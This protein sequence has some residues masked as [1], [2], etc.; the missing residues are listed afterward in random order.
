E[1]A[2]FGKFHL[3]GPENNEADNATPSVLGWDY[4]YGWVGGLP[5]SVDP[6]AGNTANPAIHTCGFLPGNG[7]IEPGGRNTGACYHADRTCTP[8]QRTSLLQDPAGLQCLDAGGIFVPENTCNDPAPTT[9]NFNFENAYY[10]SP[11]VIIDK[12]AVEK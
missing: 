7:G 9:L 6:R 4:F 12:G 10:V 3:A 8:V 1:S 11:L 5:G 2:M